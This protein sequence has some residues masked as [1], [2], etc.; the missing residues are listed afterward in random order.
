MF[1]KWQFKGLI[2]LPQ[3]RDIVWNPRLSLYMVLSDKTV[4]VNRAIDGE[5][6]AAVNLRDDGQ[7]IGAQWELAEGKLF[8]L[9]YDS[10]A[11]RIYDCSTGGSLREVVNLIDEGQTTDVTVD[12]VVWSGAQW[13]Q[14]RQEYSGLNIEITKQLPGMVRLVRDAKQLSVVPLETGKLRWLADAGKDAAIFLGHD[15]ISG[16]YLMTAD[17]LLSVRVPSGIKK[18]HK[19]LRQRTNGTFVG[20]GVDGAVQWIT[21][22]FLNSALMRE[23]IRYSGQIRF[24]CD[25]LAENISMCKTDLIEPYRQFLMR[26]A[27]AYD[28]GEL[29]SKFRDIIISGYIPE[30]LEDW[31]CNSIGDKNYKRWKQ[32][33]TRMY[34]DLNNVL[35]LAVIPACERLILAAEQLQGIHKSLKLQE[36]GLASPQ[37]L[38]STEIA[39]LIDVCQTLLRTSLE[40]AVDLNR[41]TRLHAIFADWFYDVVM[42]TVDE[43][44]KR[45]QCRDSHQDCY[46]DRAL[47]LDRYISHCW[48]DS[49][50][51][52]RFEQLLPQLAADAAISANKLDHIY[53]RAWV[54]KQ[55]HVTHPVRACSV[56]S[57][58]VLDVKAYNKVIMICNVHNEEGAGTTVVAV[59]PPI[60]NAEPVL[61]SVKLSIQHVTK[62]ALILPEGAADDTALVV[63]LRNSGEESPSVHATCVQFGAHGAHSEHSWEE[64]TSKTEAHDPA[65]LLPVHV[66][67]TPDGAAVHSDTVIAVFENIT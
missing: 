41:D 60:V 64:L 19:I 50:I 3:H 22:Q 67:A 18:M 16:D 5:R 25:Y 23:L 20:V 38:E 42:E 47:A 2:R 32:L 56:N 59:E 52:T 66:S 8:A 21:L 10:G 13:A 62:A 6:I 65:S 58:E 24:L 51:W 15:E 63:A 37:E 27:G 61:Q 4:S 40:L 17:G 1:N 43:D 9:F 39:E 48:D 46:G 11:V 34:G 44:Y 53:T 57:A 33:S 7:L 30:D 54:L 14:F 55:I 12:T 29:P 49:E 36:F 45:P 28:G 31:L 35:V 26:I